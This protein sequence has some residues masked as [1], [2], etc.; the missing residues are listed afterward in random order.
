MVSVTRDRHAPGARVDASFP[1]PPRSAYAPSPTA[2]DRPTSARQ[3]ALLATLA[4]PDDDGHL[5]AIRE[6]LA[7]LARVRV[8]SM[9]AE[10]HAT[11]RRALQAIRD[12][13]DALLRALG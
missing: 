13:A 12:R 3:S 8:R 4:P 7:A 2:S 11:A 5:G 6:S 1:E 9:P 10:A